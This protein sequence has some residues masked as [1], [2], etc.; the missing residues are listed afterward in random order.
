ML[1]PRAA[2]NEMNAVGGVA[3]SH[4]VEL[5]PANKSCCGLRRPPRAGSARMHQ[6]CASAAIQPPVLAV[7][8]WLCLSRARMPPWQKRA[9]VQPAV[10]AQAA[11]KPSSLLLPKILAA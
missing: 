9:P 1:Q 4:V 8:V 10:A 11:L 7:S 2:K 3:A 5:S 6:C